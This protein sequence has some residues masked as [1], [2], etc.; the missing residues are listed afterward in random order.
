MDTGVGKAALASL[1]AAPAEKTHRDLEQLYADSPL[2]RRESAQGDSDAEGSETAASS[3]RKERWAD[4][5]D[6]R[7]SVCDTEWEEASPV[8][9]EA[10]AHQSVPEWREPVGPGPP[11]QFCAWPED[12]AGCWGHGAEAWGWA[13]EGSPQHQQPWGAHWEAA[14]F[15]F[16]NQQMQPV[17]VF[18]M[19]CDFA[20]PQCWTPL[21]QAQAP[22]LL[23][24]RRHPPKPP[25]STSSSKAEAHT[26]VMMRNVPI[27]Y[28]R[29]MLLELLDRKGFARLY[30]FVYLPF[31]FLTQG[32]VGYAFINLV[33]EEQA[34]L[35]WRTFQGFSDWAVSS[36]KVC[37]LSWSD[38]GQGREANIKRYRNSPVMCRTVPDVYKPALFSDG[39]RV[40]FPAPSK[41]LKPPRIKPSTAAGMTQ[42]PFGC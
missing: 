42:Q 8:Y 5:E 19:P 30:N 36:R 35:F 16:G 21:E 18:G 11:P 12:A 39:V 37:S 32:N 34:A 4:M 33:S 3:G 40:T 2:C 27:S 13:A 28:S 38:Q 9:Y 41:T 23:S 22:T 25:K 6:D 26:T 15:Q 1:A 7:D 10:S 20:T 14:D 29:E 24:Q 31:D 17:I